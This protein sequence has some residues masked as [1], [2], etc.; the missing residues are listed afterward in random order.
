VRD[1]ALDVTGLLLSRFIR[2]L[3]LCCLFKVVADGDL[4]AWNKALW[5]AAIYFMP[6]IAIPAY[7][8]LSDRPR[9]GAQTPVPLAV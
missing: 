7:F 5:L 8:L 2:S 1:I 9:G 3:R 6:L 4:V